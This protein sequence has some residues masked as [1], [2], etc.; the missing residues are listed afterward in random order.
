[1]PDGT[2][3]VLKDIPSRPAS[4]GNISKAALAAR[5]SPVPS[6]EEINRKVA[7]QLA[8]AARIS[9]T[10]ERA[11][12]TVKIDALMKS[13]AE[14]RGRSAEGRVRGLDPGF[15]EY[16]LI[17][18][19]DAER[20]AKALRDGIPAR[21]DHPK[22]DA[23]DLQAA[24][25]EKRAADL[26]GELRAYHFAKAREFHTLASLARGEAVTEASDGRSV[27]FTA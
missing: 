23:F 13:A 6:Q 21:P 9:E 17:K 26:Q 2:I 8:K 3:I 5:S 15:R 14:W 24:E 7:E 4:P 12:R 27:S 1:M 25:H 10:T 11:E 22:A 19:A 20:A 18:A 16:L